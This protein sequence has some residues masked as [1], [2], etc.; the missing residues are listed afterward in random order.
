MAYNP[1]KVFLGAHFE[2][3]ATDAF[4]DAAGAPPGFDIFL[5]LPGDRKEDS[6]DELPGDRSRRWEISQD[7]AH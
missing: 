4:V 3:E 5:I 1:V 6:R 2:I 7:C